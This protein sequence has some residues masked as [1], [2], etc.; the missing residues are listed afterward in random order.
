[1][2]GAG[3]VELYLPWSGFESD[4]RLDAEGPSVRVL[5][6]PS[7]DASE[8]ARRFYPDWDALAPAA[9]QLLARDAH[10]VL[11]ADLASPA[12]LVVCWTADGSLDGK[13]LYDDGTGQ[14]LRIAHDHGILVRNLARPDDVEELF[15]L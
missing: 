14:A 12:R 8:L 5:S 7:A 9:R 3:G 6:Q 11:G 15:L 1:M 10:Q 2:I 13:D 4:A